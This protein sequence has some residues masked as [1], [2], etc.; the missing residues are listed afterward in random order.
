MNQK[1]KCTECK[2]TGFQ[3]PPPDIMEP[4]LECPH[5]KCVECDGTGIEQRFQMMF[6]LYDQFPFV[7]A[8][9]GFLRDDGTCYCPAYQACFRPAKIMTLEEGKKIALALEQLTREHRLAMAVVNNG[10][11]DR[12]K[13][14]IPWIKKA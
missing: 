5:V 8:S 12:L 6:W 2:G 10:Y 9:Q 4:R 3:T 11:M 14:L 1:H 13:D 7:L